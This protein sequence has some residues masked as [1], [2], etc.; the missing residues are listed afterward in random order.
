MT[1]RLDSEVIIIG[2]GV[3]AH[4]DRFGKF[5]EEEMREY[6]S[7]LVPTPVLREALHAEQ[8]VIYGCLTLIQ[9]LR[10]NLTA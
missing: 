8:A 7:D 6:S 9:Q 2:G 4:F 10:H 1:G 5:L 3:G